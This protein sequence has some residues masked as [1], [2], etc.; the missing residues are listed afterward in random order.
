MGTSMWRSGVKGPGEV[1]S[2]PLSVRFVDDLPG[3]ATG[4]I[5][6]R[7]LIEQFES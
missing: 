6:R 3:T 7:E 4:G 1:A 2:R 5:G